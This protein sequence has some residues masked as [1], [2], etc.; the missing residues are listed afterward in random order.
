MSFLGNS[1]GTVLWDKHTVVNRNKSKVAKGRS[2]LRRKGGTIILN[3]VHWRRMRVQGC[4]FPAAA[5]VVRSWRWVRE[6]SAFVFLKA[7]S[8]TPM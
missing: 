8:E 2:V 1:R 5:A 6:G 4:S 3:Q 7:G